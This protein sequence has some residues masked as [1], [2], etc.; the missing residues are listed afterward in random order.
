MRRMHYAWWVCV[1]CA[2]LL[3]CTAG[4][5]INVF[6]IYQPFILRENGF[7]NAQA[8]LLIT[9]RSL[10]S[11]FASMLV[12]RFY[13]TFSLRAGMA[14]AGLTSAL[15]YVVYGATRSYA[16]YCC[17]SAL[18]GVGFGIGSTTPVAL[19][20]ERW[21]VKDRMLAVSACSAVTGLS[22][23]GVPS[24]LTAIIQRQGL[25]TAFLL[26]GAV[27][28]GLMLLSFA[29]LRDDPG[30]MG[31]T[32]YGEGEA[33]ASRQ[34][35]HGSVVLDRRDRRVLAPMTI[36]AGA[37]TSVGYSHLGVYMHSLGYPPEAIAVA[38]T[39]SGLALMLGK[40]LFGA[41]A[42]RIGNRRTILTFGAVLLAGLLLC[43]LAQYGLAVLYAAMA[44][45]GAG[46]SL[47]T[48]GF[49]ACAADWSVADHFRGT[50][51]QFQIGYFAGALAFSPVPG[52]I[53]DR[54]GGAY[55]PTFVLFLACG[56]YVVLA[57][58]LTYRRKKGQLPGE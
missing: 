53:A 9:V 28:A 45:Y 50:V 40:L 29:L 57:I 20:I 15:G 51:E 54:A 6:T 27:I 55:L 32:R 39:I 12:E 41:L 42:E 52:L 7:T 43:C 4:L 26:E 17:A 34:R 2:L 23:F 24:L 48:V 30:R 14:L 3:F 25:R 37:L 58:A 1:G 18:V 31:L 19:L 11:F 13:R 21:F 22:T 16:G 8:S 38:I 36:A 44:A 46:L 49:T 33:V 35:A 47:T 56:A 5:A 10:A